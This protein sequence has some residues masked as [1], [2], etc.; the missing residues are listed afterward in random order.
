M[1]AICHSGHNPQSNNNG[2]IVDAGFHQNY[3]ILI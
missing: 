1:I 3:K 2:K